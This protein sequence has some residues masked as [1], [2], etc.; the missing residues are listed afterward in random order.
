MGVRTGLVSLAVGITLS[1]V[2]IT[3]GGYSHSYMTMLVGRILFGIAS[4]SLVTAQASMVSFWFKG[5]EL[6]LALGIAVTF[7][8]LGNALNSWLTPLFY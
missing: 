7:P 5:K 8:E 6:A 3:I 4:E 1:Q 2:V